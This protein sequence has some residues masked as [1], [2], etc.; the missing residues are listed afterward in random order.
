MMGS[1]GMI[2]MDEDTCMV[3]VAKYFMNFLRDESCGKCL[4]C[5]EGTQRLWEIL[6]RI[7]RGQG[8]PS[9]IPLLEELAVAVRDASMC[10]L[11]QTAANPIL[12]TLHYFRD[13]YEAHIL[14]KRCPAVVCKE[15]I[16]SPC[17]HTCPIGTE[18]PQYIGYI[19]RGELEKAYDIILKDNPLLSVCGR[20][21]H[22][23]C[24]TK[25][26]AGQGGDPIA[27]RE[28]KRFAAAHGNGRK[29]KSIKAKPN[30]VKIAIVGAGPAGLM[31]GYHLAL[32]GYA[33]VIFE[34]HPVPGGMLAVGIPEYRLPRAELNADIKR[35]T[36]AGVEIKT[37]QRLGKDFKVPDLFDQGYRA[38][39]IA[40]GAH[41][42]IKLGVPNEDA[43][44]VIAGMDFL[45]QVHLGKKIKLGKRI[46]VIGGGN[47]AVDAARAA[48]RL[49]GVDKV[50][51]IYRRTVAEMPAYREEVES[52]L[53]EGIE[54]K[55][56]TAPTKVLLKDGK[57]TGVECQKMQLGDI[58][59]SGRRRPVPVKGS[60]YTI[61]LDTVIRAISEQPDMTCLG[62]EHNFKI[63]GWNT[64]QVEPGTYA[65]GV[66]GVFAG[67]DAIRGPSSVIEAMADGKKVAE[68]IDRYVK[69]EKMELTYAVTRPTVYADPVKLSEEELLLVDRQKPK[70]LKAGDRQKNFQE[71]DLG[72]DKASAVREAKRCLRCDLELLKSE[73]KEKK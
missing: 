68:I 16:S 9:D 40:I 33:P 47:S 14:H 50:T 66:P 18:A 43:S 31:A 6:D 8:Q 55:Y 58:D 15:I 59:E 72:F 56:L 1:G 49:P 67:G 12:S 42:S 26:R 63:S 62:N 20:V 73:A 32:N 5:R 19:A 37:N 24:E 35:V 69:G 11:G 71:V 13:E 2:V 17:Q 4:S 53:E 45:T 51:I 61:E 21:C 38:V 22:H 52:A 3:D 7:T 64:F 34:A 57:V 65:T 39:F 46:G 29:H 10:G 41:K 23:P 36:E 27:I 28:L 25:C 70:R 60:E 44:G 30:G 48:N 54:I